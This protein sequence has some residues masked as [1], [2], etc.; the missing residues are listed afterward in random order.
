MAPAVHRA[1]AATARRGVKNGDE[2]IEVNGRRVEY[3]V[4][5]DAA[6]GTVRAAMLAACDV[7]RD[8]PWPKRLVF[9]RAGKRV[10]QRRFNMSGP[11]ARAPG[12]AST[13]RKRS[14]R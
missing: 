4:A 6:H 11:R 14:E 9:R 2:L 10:V 1:N 13:L 8:A 12:K 7:V 3:V 5:S